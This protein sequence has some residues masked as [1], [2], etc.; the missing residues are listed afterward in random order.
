MMGKIKVM[1]KMSNKLLTKIRRE[2][3]IQS[4]SKNFVAAFCWFLA[5]KKKFFENQ[6]MFPKNSIEEKVQLRLNN[7]SG[8]E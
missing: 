1:L 3:D 4:D 2:G 8:Q 6:K 7:L 5:R